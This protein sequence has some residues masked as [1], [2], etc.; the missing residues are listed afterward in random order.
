MNRTSHWKLY[1]C[2][3]LAEGR[4]NCSF[5]YL[6]Q[7]YLGKKKINLIMS[8]SSYQIHLAH[9]ENTSVQLCLF[10]GDHDWSSLL[11]HLVKAIFFWLTKNLVFSFQKL[12]QLNWESLIHID[13]DVRKIDKLNWPIKEKKDR[14]R[15][16]M[17]S[18]EMPWL[19]V[20]S[21]NCFSAWIFLFLGSVLINLHMVFEML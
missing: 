10:K 18:H 1:F 3:I 15:N 4:A 13:Q 5:Q 8:R 20:V 16:S 9:T 2:L 17:I 7:A 12:A 11:N 6:R 14:S 19:I 21:E